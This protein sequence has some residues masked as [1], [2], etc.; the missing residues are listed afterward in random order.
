MKIY[1]IHLKYISIENID[2]NLYCLNVYAYIMK[3]KRLRLYPYYMNDDMAKR[4]EFFLS[5]SRNNIRSKLIS[6][7]SDEKDLAN[8]ELKSKKQKMNYLHLELIIIILKL[9]KITILK[10]LIY[11]KIKNY[12]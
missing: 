6:K 2:K 4:G 11:Q 8:S 7:K 9:I 3:I 10:K 5:K 1:L 12:K